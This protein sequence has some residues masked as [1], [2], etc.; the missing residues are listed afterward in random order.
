M[1]IQ[2]RPTRACLVVAVDGGV[3]TG[4]SSVCS[5]LA[6]RLRVPYFNAGL[7]YRAL[8]L[9]CLDEHLTLDNA[10]NATAIAA[11][12][13]PILV[14]LDNGCTAVSLADRDVS[15]QLELAEITAAVSRV[16]RHPEVREVMN[17][18]QREI[19]E[20]AVSTFN[21]VVID[22]RDATTVV[23]PNADV[24]VLLVANPAARASRVSAGEGE[25]EA[26]ARDAADA[27]VSDFLCPQSGV[28][29]FDTSDLGIDE[30]S[31]RVLAHVLENRPDWK[32]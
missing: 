11:Q 31:S 25:A 15:D 6:Q 23:V 19:V 16:S 10:D 7:L 2:P 13:F 27:V 17:T 29:A 1:E 32:D 30:I 14:S 22:G 8:A 21:G 12:S 24:K 3:A 18:R 20:Q 5:V 9:W 28:A 4:K 26:A